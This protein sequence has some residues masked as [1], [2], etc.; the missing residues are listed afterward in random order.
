M[1]ATRSKIAKVPENAKTCELGGEKRPHA[2][3]TRGVVLAGGVVEVTHPYVACADHAQE[4]CERFRGAFPG[5][6][7]A[8]ERLDGAKT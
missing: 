7:F 3:L 5:T 2:E 8:W 6:R 1:H 4:A